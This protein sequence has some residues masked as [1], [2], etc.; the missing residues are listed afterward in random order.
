M[1]TAALTDALA[2]LR[3]IHTPPPPAWW[4]PAPLWWLVFA[5]MLALLA[6]WIVLWQRWT[7]R[8]AP[9][10][11]ALQELRA[12]GRGAQQTDQ[13]ASATIA[14][15]LRRVLLIRDPLLAALP[16]EEALARSAPKGSGNCSAELAA[17]LR[18]RFS[19]TPAID[20]ATLRSAAE[21]WLRQAEKR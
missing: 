16:L 11:Q 8:R 21:R 18:D 9:Y 12:M 15:L 14:V 17:L 20:I 2:Q 19:A 7:Q 10:V 13:G 3:D 5:V 1:A 4:P 6:T